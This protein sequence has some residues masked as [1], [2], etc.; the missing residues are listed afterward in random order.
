MKMSGGPAS[1]NLK[2]ALLFI[3]VAIAFGTWY[4]TQDLVTKLQDREKQ[5]IELYAEGLEYIASENYTADYTFVF[6][7]VIKKIK[8][9]DFPVILT[10]A[11]DSVSIG[12]YTESILNVN[13]D[14]GLKGKDLENAVYKKLG[15]LKNIHAPIVVQ[16]GDLII[17]KI[18]YG[19]S[20][21]ITQLRYYPYFQIAFA[22]FFL[23]IAY[24]SFRSIKKHEQSN[25]FVG[26]SKETAHQL[27]TPVSS[28]MG[29]SE[30]LRINYENPDK[31]IDAADEIDSD[32]VRLTKIAQR[33]SKI[34][35][36]PELKEGNP[37]DVVERVLKYFQRRIPQT[38]NDVTLN[39]EG[40][41]HIIT[42][43]NPELFEWVIEN[44]IKNA[45]DAI[46]NKKGLIDFKVSE[47]PKTWEVEVTDNGKGIDMRK[48]KD[49][50]RPGY[51]TKRRGWGM[52][53]SLSK[54]IVEDYHK[55]KIFVKNSIIGEGTTFKIILKKVQF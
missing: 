46:E 43:L 12:G 41:K 21:L 23:L 54:R 15:E 16:H 30:L 29:W 52:G 50:F 27:G 38:G 35:S 5:T 19:D 14:P 49:I 11:K 25:I 6:D 32:L 22:V 39:L 28:L 37:Y 51:S 9:V 55:G 48:R 20:N 33:F 36:K 44:L 53:L 18:Y 31:V 40:P 8:S 1:V 10:D 45:L 42:K 26:M 24:M 17:Q 2:I 13:I 34:G 3:A 47:T 4:Y 7:K